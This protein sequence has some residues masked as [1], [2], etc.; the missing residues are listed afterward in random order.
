[1]YQR[2]VRVTFTRPEAEVI[3]QAL[4][5]LSADPVA[6]ANA[7]LDST[8]TTMNRCKS[9]WRRIEGAVQKR[10]RA[11]AAKLVRHEKDNPPLVVDIDVPL[12]GI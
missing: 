7:G 12:E 1:M 5:R 4:L 8:R 9:A 3:R 6:R 2:R 11:M 10:D